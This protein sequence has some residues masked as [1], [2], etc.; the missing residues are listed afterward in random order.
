MGW[1]LIKDIARAK[2][3]VE[4]LARAMTELAV[5]ESLT[6]I[7]GKE[8]AARRYAEIGGTVRFTDLGEPMIWED[9]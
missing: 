1:V 8:Y 2:D 9:E 6:L 5:A 7:H 4:L 3:P